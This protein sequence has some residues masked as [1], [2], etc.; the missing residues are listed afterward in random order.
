M[1]DHMEVDT[2]PIKTDNG[3][4]GKYF[5]AQNDKFTDRIAANADPTIPMVMEFSSILAAESTPF[6]QLNIPKVVCGRGVVSEVLKK[7]VDIKKLMHVLFDSI[8]QELRTDTFYLNRYKIMSKIMVMEGMIRHYDKYHSQVVTNNPLNPFKDVSW[9][10]VHVGNQQTLIQIA[11]L[12]LDPT[13]FVEFI[14]LAF[15]ATAHSDTVDFM[16]EKIAV[17]PNH[18]IYSLIAQLDDINPREFGLS[19]IFEPKKSIHPILIV[20]LDDPFECLKNMNIF[21]VCAFNA[22]G[23]TSIVSRTYST[24][25]IINASKVL[26]TTDKGQKPQTSINLSMFDYIFMRMINMLLKVSS[27]TNMTSLEMLVNNK[28]KGNKTG[29]DAY[30]N[31]VIDKL[32]NLLMDRTPVPIVDLGNLPSKI[33]DHEF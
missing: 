9:F 14:A 4:D 32:K 8:R 16:Y 19:I 33:E 12:M 26:G 17:D 11:A 24:E 25:T 6:A 10:N 13:S 22:T 2:L 21:K 28:L 1:A 5:L 7:A 3:T 15:Y 23:T 18:Y 30:I 20:I 31:D 29:R 27:G